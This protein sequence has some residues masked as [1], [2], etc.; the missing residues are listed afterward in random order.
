[1]TNIKKNYKDT[2]FVK[3][4]GDESNKDNLLSLYNALNHTEY[5]NEDL[6][7]VTTIENVIYMSMKN[8]I[9]C[10]IDHHMVLGE[11]QSTDNSNMPVRGLM[12]F[13]RLYNEY[14][15]QHHLNLYSSRLLKFPT[16]R[17]YVFYNGNTDKPNLTKLRLSDSFIYADN[18]GDFE[19]TATVLNIN[20]GHN[21]ELLASCEVLRGY[22]IFVAK[23]KTYIRKGYA[24]D[25][26]VQ[27]SVDEC[28]CENIL[29]EYLTAHKAEVIGM[30]I[31][32]YNE[33]ETLN[34][35]RAEIRE[36]IRDEVRN[37]VKNEVRNE[38]RN[39][40][41]NEVRN[42]IRNEIRNEV[43]NEVRDE[44]R[45]EVRVTEYEE[46]LKSLIHILKKVTDNFET[47]C[48][49]VTDDEKYA[50]VTKE[51]IRKYW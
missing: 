15:K 22:A 45:D 37:E 35:I 41:R 2:F 4:F 25:T 8:D 23:V 9:S 11:H 18:S 13:G 7:E 39:E 28:I 14:I 17:Y 30:C 34:A 46:S 49:I 48:Q 10:I 24:V 27:R 51:Q 21:K 47:V 1:M 42:E 5:T 32:E 6:V 44:V 29:Q 36:D 38:I 31:T 43:R 40:V 16:P 50:E 33:E 26:A 19:W 12:Y 20:Y 3:L